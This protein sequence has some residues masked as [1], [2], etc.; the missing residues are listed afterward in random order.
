M[1][2]KIDVLAAKQAKQ[3]K[4][5]IVLGVVLA[6]AVA[7]QAPKLLGGSDT[8]T[9]TPTTSIDGTGGTASSTTVTGTPPVDLSAA[10]NGV[11][12]KAGVSQLA[13][14]SLFDTK[15][16][17]VQGIVVKT[18]TAGGSTGAKSGTPGA[19]GG[20]TP[21][22]GGGGTVTPAEPTLAFATISIN[23]VSEPVTVKGA[24]PQDDPTFVLA[25]LKPKLAKIG[26]AGGTLDDGKAA[27][28][29]LGKK[30]TLVNNATG[31]RYTLELLYVGSEPE[32][33]A[34]FTSADAAGADAA[35]TTAAAT[36]TTP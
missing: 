8:P 28:L 34:G 6:A 33:I 27:R 2:A 22:A 16:P 31:A 11:G 25:S 5:L 24:F 23:G 30:L 19:A 3:K 17:F 14:F 9:A 36:T 10:G 32:Q 7:F 26:I 18:A 29:A 15:D 12:A 20:S 4:F 21:G 13:S 1:A 35:G